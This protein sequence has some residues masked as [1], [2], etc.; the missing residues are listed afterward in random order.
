MTGS[1]LQ[2]TG[3]GRRIDS[4]SLRVRFRRA[5]S[6]SAASCQIVRRA[7]WHDCER[8]AGT[9]RVG[10]RQKSARDFVHGATGD[11]DVVFTVVQVLRETCRVATFV[12]HAYINPRSLLP[13]GMDRRANIVA[14]RHITIQDEDRGLGRIQSDRP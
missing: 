5:R 2:H 8:R 13:E 12:C 6:A 14:H 7:E 11:H 4:C 3:V 10:G 9:L 1:V